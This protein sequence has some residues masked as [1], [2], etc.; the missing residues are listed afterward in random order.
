MAGTFQV[1]GPNTTVRFTYTALT[2]QVQ[3][4]IINAA[5]YLWEKQYGFS[6]EA[7][8]AFAALTNQQKLNLVDVKV[9]SG[10]LSLANSYRSEYDQR[11]ARE[12]ALEYEVG[13]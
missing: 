12:L 8:A 1:I 4:A 3:D 2:T 13:T 6:P 9:R 5:H 7:E 10:I 11:I